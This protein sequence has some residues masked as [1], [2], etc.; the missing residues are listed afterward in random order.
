MVWMAWLMCLHTWLKGQ[1]GI[2][3][4]TGRDGPPGLKGEKVS[5]NYINVI[6]SCAFILKLAVFKGQR[7]HSRLSGTNRRPGLTRVTRTDGTSRPV[8]VIHVWPVPTHV[9]ADVISAQWKGPPGIEGLDGKDGKP[10]LRVSRMMEAPPHQWW[11]S[12]LER[13]INIW[14][15]TIAI[16]SLSGRTRPSRPDWTPWNSSEYHLWHEP[17]PICST[18]PALKITAWISNEQ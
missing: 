6:P 7:W 8:H 12:L 11:C 15:L 9:W 18:H 14:P 1:P 4:K 2:T 16:V 17:D 5:T 13:E 3:G 10:G